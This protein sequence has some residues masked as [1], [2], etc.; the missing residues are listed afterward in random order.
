MSNEEKGIVVAT[1]GRR[2]EVRA[3]DGSRL[4]CEVRGKVKSLADS[5]TPVAVGD[6]VLFI[7]THD[8][9]GAIESVE[10]RKTS[11]HRPSIISDDKR[12]VIA[13]N[14]DRLAIVVAS[15]KPKLKTGLIDRFLIAPRLSS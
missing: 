8:Q 12:Q 1:R 14:L 2:F 11:F 13:A 4:Q 10:E 6:S 15:K 3:E 5:T 7:R 9:A